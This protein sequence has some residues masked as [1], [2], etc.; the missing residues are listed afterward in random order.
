VQR[1]H[2]ETG[3]LNTLEESLKSKRSTELLKLCR[4]LPGGIE[5][6]QVCTR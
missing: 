3:L 2:K 5:Q 1:R 4:A 6:V